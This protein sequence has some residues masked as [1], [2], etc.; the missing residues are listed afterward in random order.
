MNTS[1]KTPLIADE[2]ANRKNED[3]SKSSMLLSLRPQLPSGPPLSSREVLETLYE[4]LDT[5]RSG[6]LDKNEFAIFCKGRFDID[7]HFSDKI[8]EAA[9]SDG[10][11][12]VDRDEFLHIM[13]VCEEADQTF[14]S[15]EGNYV[16]GELS[17]LAQLAMC[18]YLCCPC[19]CGASVCCYG[20][21][22]SSKMA[23]LEAR[24]KSS[25]ARKKE[26]VSTSLTIAVRPIDR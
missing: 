26:F 1:E 21:F 15:Q 11:N 17:L 3:V 2:N 10:N 12:Q 6:T 22:A 8:F 5:D 14:T 9:D 7:Q 19:T 18:A 4:Q 25:A 16:M 23:E 24:S 20:C 13:Q